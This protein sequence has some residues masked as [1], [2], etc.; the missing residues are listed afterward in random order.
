MQNQTATIEVQENNNNYGI[1]RLI[2]TQKKLF[3]IKLAFQHRNM[4]KSFCKTL[5]NSLI[6]H[7]NTVQYLMIVNGELLTNIFLYF[8]NLKVLILDSSYDFGW[9]YLQNLSLPFLQTLKAS[10]VPLKAVT[11]LIKNTSDHLLK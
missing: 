2:K 6:R 8:V 11:S 9:N 7:A 5:E 3:S 4:D 1:I 10:W